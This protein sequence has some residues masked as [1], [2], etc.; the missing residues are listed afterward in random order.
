MADDD[1]A[2]DDLPAAI[3]AWCTAVHTALGLGAS[4]AAGDGAPAKADLLDGLRALKATV[5]ARMKASDPSAAAVTEAFRQAAA[6]AKAGDLAAATMTM[7]RLERLLAGPAT[8][9]TAVET[10]AEDFRASWQSARAAWQ[11]ASDRVD[12]QLSA[13][14]RVLLASGDPELGQIAE[15]GLN[16]VTGNN[17]VRLMAAIREID[18]APGLAPQPLLKRARAAIDGLETS[19]A[20]DTRVVAC[21]GNPFDVP[22][23][24][25]A[26]LGP[27]LAKLRQAI[28]KAEA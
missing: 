14:R 9:E 5:G 21:D 1:P 26:T 23:S 11:D 12:E 24:I 15:V 6:Q 22:V 19:I 20:S 4:E 27:A 18:A 8:V 10:T 7:E 17:R 16:A 2:T 13:L 25:G 3:R 28:A